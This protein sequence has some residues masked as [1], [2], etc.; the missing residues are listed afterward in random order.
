M[1][2]TEQEIIHTSERGTITLVTDENGCEYVRKTGSF[3][4]ET[5]SKIAEINSPFIARIADNSDTEIVME[6]VSGTPLSALAVPTSQLPEIVCEICDGLT[7]LHNAG[8]IHRDI[9]PS[10]IMLTDYG[11][12]KIIDFDAARVKK[13]E[14]EKDTSFIG[15]DGFAPPEQYGFTQTDERSDIYALG[16]T[17][18]LLLKENY[19]SSF[20]RAVAEKCMRFNPDERYSSAQKVKRA[21]ILRRY[22]AVP[23]ACAAVIAVS[24]IV[25]AVT[26][27]INKTNDVPVSAPVSETTEQTVGIITDAVATTNTDASAETTTVPQTSEIITAEQTVGIITDVVTTVDTSVFTEVTTTSQ[28]TEMT[29]AAEAAKPEISFLPK[30]FPALPDDITKVDDT[31]H[32]KKI[33]WEKLGQDDIS[34]LIDNITE[35][36][37][38]SAEVDDKSTR[39]GR[40]IQW[41]CSNN[42]FSGYIILLYVEDTEKYSAFPQCRLSFS[43]IETL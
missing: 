35:W 3:N 8:V 28:T 38:E 18:K 21:V 43:A 9:K 20:L 23:I 34:T 2:L 5:L 22:R 11:H 24:G 19:D 42:T 16:V 37:G 14:A 25:L 31:E 13:P 30:G 39:M 33:E 32:V 1:K 6:Y 4:T 17:I 10:N 29:S 7:A 40:T 27:V 41:K 15:T 26:F 36:L 12:I